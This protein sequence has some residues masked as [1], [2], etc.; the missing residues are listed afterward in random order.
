[1]V[2]GTE[3]GLARANQAGPTWRPRLVHRFAGA[4]GMLVVLAGLMAVA[5]YL[6][7]SRIAAADIS[8]SEASDKLSHLLDVERHFSLHSAVFESYIVSGDLNVKEAFEGTTRRNLDLA[9]SDMA[10]LLAMPQLLAAITE[11]RNSAQTA[12]ASMMASPQTTVLRDKV[13]ATVTGKVH[14]LRGEVASLQQDKRIVGRVAIIVALVSA[15]FS[16]VG[17]IASCFW[18]MRRCQRPILQLTTAMENITR[19]EYDGAIP[20]LN[21]RTEIGDMAQAVLEL[22]DARRESARLQQELQA[23]RRARDEERSQ[24]ERQLDRSVGEVVVAAV[25]GDLHRRIETT[26][27]HG[28]MQ[29]LGDQVNALLAAFGSAVQELN[30]V[31]DSMAHGDLT[32][33]M[34][35]SYQG[36]FAQLQVNTNQTTERLSDM[37]RQIAGAAG[38]VRDASGEIAAG[39][40]DLA[41]RTEQ[42]AASLEETAASM[43]EITATVKQNADSAA[44]ASRLADAARMTADQGGVVAQDAI[45]AMSDI[46]QAAQHISDI[47]GLIDEIAFQTN[48]L[49]LNASVEAARA[50]EAGKGFAVVAQEVRA[51]AQRSANA[52]KDIKNLIQ[53]SNS[54]VRGGAELVQ[55]AGRALDE[56]VVSVKQVADLVAEISAASQEQATGLEA[57]NQAVASMDEVTQRNGALVEQTAVSAQ[58]MGVEAGRLN[59]LV[60]GFKTSG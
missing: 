33:R 21:D 3:A 47:V 51:L 53:S 42:Q 19:G 10:Q 59:Q 58:A 2:A 48:L 13:Y 55:R 38:M 15:V 44:A 49:A 20:G 12:A 50:G 17:A 37:M 36:V 31:L 57:L 30:R 39:A 1:M 5:V 28:V 27:L 14:E 18:L 24:Q 43:H 41:G 29:R 26:A 7:Q 56:I 9:S 45:R 35:G 8:L 46:E 23:E 40:N 16:A 22:R 34:E 11:W 52:G 4:F 6:S 32:R 25:A 54:K 60:A